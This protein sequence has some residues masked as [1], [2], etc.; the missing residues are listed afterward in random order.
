[1]NDRPLTSN[2]VTTRVAL[3]CMGMSGA[4]GKTDDAQPIAVIQAA[5][6]RGV[7]A[8]RGPEDAIFPVL[9]ECGIGA[10]LYG[11]LSRGLLSASPIGAGDARA[12]MPRFSGANRRSEHQAR[13][14]SPASREAVGDHPQ[15][16]RDRLGI[17][18]AAAVRAARC[19]RG[20]TLPSR[21]HDVAR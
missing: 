18:Q 12:H 10:T 11:V 15:S 9:A 19:D 13:D 5:I 7:I 6:G 17:G 1:M 4:Y 16:A 20:H 3:G 14:G 21:T 8:S 2:S